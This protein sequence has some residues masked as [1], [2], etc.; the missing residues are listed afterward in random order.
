MLFLSEISMQPRN[1]EPPL[2]RDVFWN[3]G[4]LRFAGDLDLKRPFLALVEQ[5]GVADLQRQQRVHRKHGVT[6]LD[7]DRYACDAK[8]GKK[9]R[10]ADDLLLGMKLLIEEMHDR[11]E[12]QHRNCEMHLRKRVSHAD[13]EPEIDHHFVRC[14]DLHQM[15]TRFDAADTEVQWVNRTPAFFQVV[16][17]EPHY[18][19][20]N[21]LFDLGHA[22][23]RLYRDSFAAE[24][25]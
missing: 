16:C 13:V 21:A 22:P 5:D 17:N 7:A 1:L 14:D 6:C 18:R 9:R 8:L 15:W 4:Q 12:N 2:S 11:L 10:V 24:Q 20:D 23:D 3:R 19:Q 25:P